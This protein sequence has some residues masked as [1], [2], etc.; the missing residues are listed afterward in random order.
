M[1]SVPR[2]LGG[3][4]PRLALLCVGVAMGGGC[5]G[6]FDGDGCHDLAWHDPVGETVTVWRCRPG[7]RDFD[8]GEPI[9]TPPQ[10]APVGVHWGF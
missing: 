9:P 1:C 7:E 2:V 6:D 8:C 3:L 4:G 5:L 10:A